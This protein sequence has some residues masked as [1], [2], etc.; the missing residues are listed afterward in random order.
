MDYPWQEI[1][2]ILSLPDGTPDPVA[3]AEY[4]T[5]YEAIFGGTRDL[6]NAHEIVQ[7]VINDAKDTV[8]HDLIIVDASDPSNALSGMNVI[9]HV[10]EIGARL[11]SMAMSPADG[12]LMLTNLSP[13]NLIRL[14]NNL[15]GNIV[16]HEVVKVESYD[17]PGRIV[18]TYN[19]HGAVPNF[20]DVS[21]PNQTAQ[22]NSLGEPRGIVFRG[23][24]LRAYVA[25]SG[26]G[27]VGVLDTSGTVLGLRDVGGEHSH[28][29]SLAV[30]SADELYV[31]DTNNMTV[32]SLDASSDTLPI[33]ESVCLYT[34]EPEFMRKGRGAMN[35]ARFT[36]NY[37]ASCATCHPGGHLDH[38]AWDLG[39][40]LATELLS[41]PHVPASGGDL[42]DEAT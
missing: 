28:P 7:D 5:A 15:R 3:V 24:G 41:I 32:T 16:E 8:D 27:R 21:A 19:L 35:S 6:L 4:E 23:D 20:D 9:E 36:N 33:T 14:E 42:C 13:N 40:G 12:S 31:L 2:D 17:S 18:S 25:A 30:S 37:G 34:I 1:V 11:R 39:N 10:G 29:V 22:A 38:T 26:V